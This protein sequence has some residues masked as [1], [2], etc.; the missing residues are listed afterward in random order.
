[1]VTF[2]A[3]TTQYGA[4]RLHKGTPTTGNLS[5]YQALLPEDEMVE[6]ALALLWHPENPGVLQGLAI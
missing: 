6:W 4:R 2:G 1:M 3:F 5:Y